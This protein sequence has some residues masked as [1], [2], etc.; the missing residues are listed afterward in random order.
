M[1]FLPFDHRKTFVTDILGFSEI[2]S[3]SQAEYVASLKWLIYQGFLKTWEAVHHDPRLGVLVDEEFGA[4]V[5][6]DVSKKQ[7]PF[8]LPIEKHGQS[9][10]D[11]A[12]GGEWNQVVERIS[13]DYVKVLVRYNPANRADNQLQLARLKQVSDY[14]LVNKRKLLFELLVPP[15]SEE[16]LELKNSYEAKKRVINTVT[17]LLELQKVVSVNLWK[18]EGFDKAGWKEVLPVIKNEVPVVVLGRGES[19]ERVR[20]WLQ[21]ASWYSRIEGFAVGRTIF[22][23]PLRK[24]VTGE[25]AEPAVIAQIAEQLTSQLELWD[26][27]KKQNPQIEL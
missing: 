14:C 16:R 12:Q 26:Q 17:A 11:F 24:F 22:L 23:A 20:E 1:I 18:L 2:I 10:F 15:T 3:P 21:A 4:D 8:G 7:I 6:A 25:I 5:I 19:H 9:V 13:P 27:E